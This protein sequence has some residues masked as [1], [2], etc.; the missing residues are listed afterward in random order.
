MPVMER[1]LTEIAE[2][3]SH[4]DLLAEYEQITDA[5]NRAPL[6]STLHGYAVLAA[7]AIARVAVL[8]AG[9]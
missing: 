8:E 6:I 9:R 7:A 2:W 4:A 5:M 3:V 1:S